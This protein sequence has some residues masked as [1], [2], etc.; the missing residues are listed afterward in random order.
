M[1][2]T[3]DTTDSKKISIQLSGNGI[4]DKIE[5]PAIDGASQTVLSSV[6]EILLS[7]HT[8]LSELEEIYV[9]AGPGSYTGVRVG[10]A[11]AHTLGWY[12]GIPVNGKLGNIIEPVYGK[13]DKF[14]VFSKTS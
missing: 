11:I 9:S 14:K 1:I 12:L 4:E 8:T 7:N 13:D 2:L 10:I 5:K 3:I 6:H